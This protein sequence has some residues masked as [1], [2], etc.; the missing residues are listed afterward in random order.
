[1]SK[2]NI[3]YDAIFKSIFGNPNVVKSF[4]QDFI[5]GGY[6]ED[7]NFSTMERIASDYTSDNYEER[8]N[9][10]VWKIS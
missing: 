10:I 2:I 5:P 8:Y 6:I 1:M 9:D 7:L 3:P 4:L